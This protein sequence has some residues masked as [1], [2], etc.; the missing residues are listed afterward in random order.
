[1]IKFTL[2]KPEMIT[3]YLTLSELE[4]ISAVLAET[5]CFDNP[6]MRHIHDLTRDVVNNAIRVEV[7]DK[8]DAELTRHREAMQR[9][10]AAFNYSSSSYV[11]RYAV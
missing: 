10:T 9:I 5:D 1:M 3:L 7:E 8:A 6:D 2:P 11:S 4:H